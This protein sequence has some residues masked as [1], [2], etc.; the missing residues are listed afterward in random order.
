MGVDLVGA[1]GEGANPP[2]TPN[3]DGLAQQ[4]L[5]FRNAWSEPICTPTRAQ[6]L[7]GRH[8]F[9]TGLGYNVFS[10]PDAELAGLDEDDLIL[11]KAL[12]GYNSSALGKWH[13]SS[14]AQGPRHP[15]MMGFGYYAGSLY[16][17]AES[18]N[19]SYYDWLKTV[20]G[21]QH[22]ETT[23]VTIDTA[24]DAIKR[25]SEM[26]PPWFLYVAFHAPHLPAHV[27]PPALCAQ[28]GTCATPYCP[29][30]EGDTARTK[31][32]ATIEALDSEIGR[33]LGELRRVD[34]DV[35]VIFVGDNGSHRVMTEAPFDRDHAKGTLYEGGIN[36]PLIISAPGY[37]T[38]E[39]DGL[40]STVDLFATVVEL[41]GRDATT[42]DSVSMVPYMTGIATGSL[43]SMVY[44]ERFGPEWELRYTRAIRD[45]R[46][47]LLRD[48]GPRPGPP[49]DELYDLV[50]DPFEQ[51]DL[52]PPV[53]EVEQQ[54][55]D[56]L[57][58]ELV[59]M[60][61]D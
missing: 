59:A 54:H 27:P 7:T 35:I 61:V 18:G 37:A 56:A 3:I 46:Y 25:A 12:D 44:S 38:G 41:A 1:Y 8:A 50:A 11:P 55:Y 5:L 14:G 32:K 43:R 24:N 15:N 23:Y 2:C 10:N 31:V 36:V 21:Q 16:N 45:E 33:M 6:I 60:G 9:R 39:V 30:D 13:L 19:G 57:L 4:G 49:R 51:N 52:Y 22:E 28:E 53:S 34:P 17:I 40:V 26:A 47:K 58:A 48:T 42:E 29:V 20:N